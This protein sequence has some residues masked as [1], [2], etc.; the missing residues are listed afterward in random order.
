[1][2][3]NKLMDLEARLLRLS[4]ELD[5]YHGHLVHRNEAVPRTAERIVKRRKYR[6][7]GPL[8]SNR[9]LS[10]K[11]M[12][13]RKLYENL[14][15]TE[16]EKTHLQY[17]LAEIL[18]K[19]QHLL[20]G[21]KYLDIE[22]SK[23]TNPLTLVANGWS[24]HRIVDRKAPDAGETH[25]SLICTCSNCHQLISFNCDK[26]SMDLSDN[27]VLR[28]WLTD[29]HLK[30]CSWRHY[31]FPLERDYYLNK[32][33]LLAE[34]LC[35]QKLNL[36]ATIEV[37]IFYRNSIDQIRYCFNIKD[38][39]NLKL[40]L[41]GFWSSNPSH[42]IK[43]FV[44]CQYCCCRSALTSLSKNDHVGHYPWCRYQDQDLL[45]HLIE[46][47]I[48]DSSYIVKELPIVARLNKLEKTL[49]KL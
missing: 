45:Y 35:L 34:F 41:R 42:T 25:N 31:Q 16:K 49:E 9:F 46:N 26:K 7:C 10:S 23:L 27:L 24:M 39:N 5:S 6:S 20:D 1:M 4:R 28:G 37:D 3:A 32:H 17:T 48:H 2:Q 40:F 36:R 43:D 30:D 12:K 29:S 8:K 33:N 15:E 47:A 11:N 19:Y 14:V 22:W 21:T 38:E 13:F 18:E 44:T